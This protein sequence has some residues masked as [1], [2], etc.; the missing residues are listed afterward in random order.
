VSDQST[1][2]I[3]E[4]VH[5]PRYGVGTVTAGG[6]VRVVIRFGEQE[7]TFVPEIAPL[8]KTGKSNPGVAARRKN[9]DSGDDD[10]IEAYRGG[11]LRA[12]PDE[13]V[14]ERNR[15]FKELGDRQGWVACADAE[16]EDEDDGLDEIA[17]EYYQQEALAKVFASSRKHARSNSKRPKGYARWNPQKKTR[18]IVSQVEEVLREYRAQLPLTAR[19]IFYRLVGAYGYPKDEK[20][21]ERLTNILVRA[22][23]AKLIP[24]EYIRDDGASVMAS[25]HYENKD[26][27]YKRIRTMGENFTLD[28]LARQGLDVRIYCEA[29][30]MMPQIRLVS[31]DYSIPVYSCS[32][33]DSLTAKYDLFTDVSRAHSWAGRRTVVLH[34]GDYD[35]S[36]E[37]IF[38]AIAEDV[39]AFLSE[40]IPH[41]KPEDVA[42]FDRVA[43][44]AEM[45][46]QYNLPTAPPKSSDSRSKAW[47]GLATCQL[48]ALPPDTL[49]DI[50]RARIEHFL[51]EEILVQDRE[52]EPEERRIIAKALPAPKGA[53]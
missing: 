2:H 7:K 31:D 42:L 48:E 14:R 19:Q 37:S 9:G 29:A 52:K 24:F 6:G 38:D 33:F 46:G 13:G 50:I 1:Y 12:E 25:E 35:P 51:S 23:R 45:V 49:A 27:F 30:G 32:G 34:L 5:H 39:H 47:T 4:E 40:A 26:E 53:A 10:G 15:A 36:G 11:A 16:D 22:R 44:T 17:S 43:L 3:G 8:T 18:I 21:Y 20:A 28:K 41:K